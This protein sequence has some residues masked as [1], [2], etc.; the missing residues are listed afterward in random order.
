MAV[1]IILHRTV[2]REFHRGQSVPVLHLINILVTLLVYGTWIIAL[3]GVLAGFARE[4]GWFQV[5]LLATLK[6]L[7]FVL[8][9]YWFFNRWLRRYMCPYIVEPDS[10]VI[11]LKERIYREAIKHNPVQ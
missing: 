6:P 11:Y 1:M 8:F 7:P 9:V 5:F 10:N 3:Y 2:E 4:A